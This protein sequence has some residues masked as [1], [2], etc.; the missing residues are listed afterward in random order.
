MK[1]SFA[2]SI[3]LLF[4][5]IVWMLLG[6]SSKPEQD[7]A[8][9]D[10]NR[11]VSVEVRDSSAQWVTSSIKAYG[12]L[13]PLRE[14]QVL[15]QTYGEVESLPKLEGDAVDQG[16]LLLTLS[17]E[18]R[19][20]KLKRAKAKTLQA[21]NRYQAT[22]NLQH[23]GFSAQQQI[24]ELFVTYEAAKAEEVIL[25]QE[26]DQLK[27]YAPFKG[28]ISNQLVEIGDY[29]FKGNPLF[30]VIDTQ[31]MVAQVAVAQNDFPFLKMGHSAQISLATGE[32]LSG[33]IRFIAPKAD[34]NT[35][36]FK[37][38]ILLENTA[39]LPSGISVTALIPKAREQAHLISSALLSLNAQ[40]VVGVKTVNEQDKVVFYP[41]QLVQAEKN[42]IYVTGLPEKV[43]L[44][45]TGQGFVQAGQKVHAVLSDEMGQPD[46]LMQQLELRD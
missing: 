2:I 45:V 9:Q 5:I 25:R 23:K 4:L 10:N 11:V 44:I 39:H 27:V 22:L 43:R 34:G 35:K 46:S 12:D 36:T 13:L 37:V 6:D 30:E 7:H 29:I 16:Q 8:L 21:K 20:A 32:E 28:I 1:H 41:V 17:I 26:M 3:G 33:K 38:E 15:A 42:G 24:D 31:S 14:T 40:G 18:D 19:E